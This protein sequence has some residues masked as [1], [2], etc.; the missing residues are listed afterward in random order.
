MRV[1]FRLHAGAPYGRVKDLGFRV[2]LQ[3]LVF[4]D[5]SKGICNTSIVGG[6]CKGGF[7]MKFQKAE[8]GFRMIAVGVYG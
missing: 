6:Y 3:C 5:A 7:T 2:E 4:S 1:L 8:H